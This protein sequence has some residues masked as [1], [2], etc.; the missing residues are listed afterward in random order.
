QVVKNGGYIII[1]ATCN[2]GA[3]QG[4]GEQRFFE[5]LK[6]ESLEQIIDHKDDFKAGEQRA[7]MMANVLKN[8]NVIIVGSKE[9]QIVKDAKMIPTSSMEEAFK[10]IQN[11]LGKNLDVILITNALLTLPIIK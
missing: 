11:D 7:F 8:C 1:P 9:Q 2:E 4:V 10:I 6:N 5:M 3:G